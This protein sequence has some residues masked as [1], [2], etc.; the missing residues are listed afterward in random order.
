[1]KSYGKLVE[2]K[3]SMFHATLPFDLTVA[4]TPPIPVEFGPA[5]DNLE[6][7]D[8]DIYQWSPTEPETVI[9]KLSGWYDVRATINFEQSSGGLRSNV[10][11]WI[12][13]NGGFGTTFTTIQ[14]TRSFGYIR[15]NSTRY[16]TVSI[17]QPLKIDNPMTSLHLEVSREN[18]SSSI[19]IPAGEASIFLQRL[20]PLQDT[21]K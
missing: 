2:Y 17:S 9:C 20:R 7:Y 21:G 4:V 12:A 1:M 5:V 11:G 6:V 15:N 3:A 8:T 10:F 13:S 19:F 18:T 16:G 14:K